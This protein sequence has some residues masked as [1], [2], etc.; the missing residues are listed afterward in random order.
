[1][2]KDLVPLG[3]PNR[4]PEIFVSYKGHEMAS[5]YVRVCE[6]QGQ[7]PASGHGLQAVP[8]YERREREENMNLHECKTL[9]A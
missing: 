4:I 7:G 3:S 5:D 8:F 1:M 2:P 9:N 6:V